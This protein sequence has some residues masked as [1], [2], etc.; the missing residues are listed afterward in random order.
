VLYKYL[1]PNLAAYLIA[2]EEHHTITFNLIDTITGEILITQEHKDSPDFR[3]P[4]DIVFGEYWVVYSYFC[5]GTGSE[6]K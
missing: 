1:Y 3:V 5:S 6:L 4:M 2:N